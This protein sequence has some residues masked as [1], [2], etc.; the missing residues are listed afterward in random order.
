MTVR[1]RKTRKRR[2]C[3]AA[4]R[5][6]SVLLLF[7]LSAAGPAFVT[8]GLPFSGST[9]GWLGS[10]SAGDRDDNENIPEWTFLIYMAAD[11]NL[12][13]AA[14]DDINEMEYVGSSDEVNIIVQIDR[15]DGYDRT[16]G[17]WTDTRRYLI[18]QDDNLSAMNSTLL[19]NLGEKQMN[20][21][22]TLTDF[23][24]WGVENY[25]ANRTA[26][27][28][29]DHGGG[30]TK[31]VLNDRGEYMKLPD[32]RRA[33]AA[34]YERT[35]HVFEIAGYDACLM[36]GMETFYQFKDYANYTVGSQKN[37]PTD[38][39]P[40]NRF[41]N[42]IVRQ[43]G[44]DTVDFLQEMTRDYANSYRGASPIAV[45]QSA[46]D[47]RALPD[48]V[49]EI[50]R[51][52]G[53]LMRYHPYYAKEAAEARNRTED[54]DNFPYMDF[55][56]F[57]RKM[58]EETGNLEFALETE[59]MLER[60]GPAVLGISQYTPSTRSSDSAENAHGFNV[61]F[62]YPNK[63]GYFNKYGNMMFTEESRWDEF[64]RFFYDYR[65]DVDFRD[66]HAPRCALVTEEAYIFD[67]DLDGDRDTILQNY[68]T[69]MREDAASRG[70]GSG[71]DHGEQV[72]VDF[73]LYEKGGPADPVYSESRTVE[74]GAPFNFSISLP[75]HSL[76]H[77]NYILTA[78]VS[79]VNGTLQDYHTLTAVM[80]RYGINMSVDETAKRLDGKM[81]T[82]FVI[83][84][85]NTGNTVENFSI[86][87]SAGTA[88]LS[89]S[90]LPVPETLRLSPGETGEAIL[91]VTGPP[92]FDGGFSFII[93]VSVSEESSVY[94]DE[95]ATV[96]PPRGDEEH[97]GFSVLYA[98]ILIA[99]I[100]A[101][102][103]IMTTL[104][105]RKEIR[106][107]EKHLAS[108]GGAAGQ[109]PRGTPEIET[110]NGDPPV[111]TVRDR[112]SAAPSRPDGEAV[113]AEQERMFSMPKLELSDDR[114]RE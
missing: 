35:H 1:R 102:G 12:E 106:K 72:L 113:P 10:A 25:P 67:S 14:M 65:D 24:V 92:G 16:D 18:R 47:V 38:G 81:R 87:I 55:M 36:G 50:D 15:N 74:T 33:F 76:P 28:L 60:I 52:A 91:Y 53:L 45:V 78:S 30:W 7:L 64:L 71:D 110:G 70:N 40:Y 4:C 48:L 42:D 98:G 114:F 103:I 54:Y 27:I 104:H 107:R 96:E 13:A 83:S 23:L 41:L 49:A 11:N 34:A 101:V 84:I 99:M 59:T 61:Y 17:D 80:K 62:P 9:G 56:D 85:E 2:A 20:Y 44:M 86:S 43:P 19:E 111:S 73:H 108:P 82:T 29:W 63:G 100:V 58:C 22:A 75:E 68:S 21:S 57:A 93:T 32:V 5:T 77:E 39:M 109:D 51:W 6:M 66:A 95:I 79:D 37:V 26:V 46:L 97:G 112:E 90:L 69:E 8:D 88:G 31:G 3:P 94:V 89:W 105:M